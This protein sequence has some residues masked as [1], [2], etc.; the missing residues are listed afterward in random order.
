MRLQ[1]AECFSTDFP[2]WKKNGRQTPSVSKNRP[3]SSL[4]TC[5][6]KPHPRGIWAR[7][8]WDA[9]RSVPL[10]Q[11]LKYPCCGVSVPTLVLVQHEDTGGLCNKL[12]RPSMW[13][14]RVK[15]STRVHLHVHLW[16]F[17]CLKSLGNNSEIKGSYKFSSNT[18]IKVGPRAVGCC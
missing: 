12:S 3:G 16:H 5:F 17:S 18:H 13:Y 6:L 9:V 2:W 11:S 4:R 14:I 15:A 8:N 10:W 1:L 7:R